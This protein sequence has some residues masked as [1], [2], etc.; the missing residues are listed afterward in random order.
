MPDSVAKTRKESRKKG[1]PG[2]SRRKAA[3]IVGLVCVGVVA[4]VVALNFDRLSA[5]AGPTEPAAP[6]A[7]TAPVILG[8]T[9]ATD[10]IEPLDVC[11]VD[12]EAVDDDGDALA[13]TWVAS[14]GD[15]AGEGAAVEWSAPEAEGLYRLSVMVDDGRGGT[16]EYSTSL[17]VRANFAPEIVSLT[18]YSDWAKPGGSTYVSCTAT[19]AD[20]DQITYE[21]SATAGEVF[22]QGSA[23]VWLAPV[24]PGSYFV[25]VIARDTYGGESSREV[26]VSVTANQGPKLGRFRVEGIETDMLDL[27]DGVWDIFQG[28]SCSIKCVVLEGSEPYTYAWTAD[29][30]TLTADGA[31]ARWDAP[32]ERGPA[33]IQV[34][35]TDVNGNTTRGVVLMYVETC[36]CMFD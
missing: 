12:C 32:E 34:D 15:V 36:T 8:V 11:R 17:R 21:W 19:D 24:E 2:G 3:V 20:G 23:I 14:Q 4:A 31:V 16:A 5:N 9:P 7:N 10:R 18:P 33:T 27:D 25:K 1:E 29:W 26:P 6:A 22:G 30:G 35:V 28:R 13:Y